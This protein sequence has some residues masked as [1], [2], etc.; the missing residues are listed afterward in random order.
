M[1][2]GGIIAA[3]GYHWLSQ[4]CNLFAI[5]RQQSGFRTNLVDGEIGAEWG[6]L[7][8]L[9]LKDEEADLTLRITSQGETATI[10]AIRLIYVESVAID[11]FKQ[12]LRHGELIPLL[13]LRGQQME[14]STILGHDDDRSTHRDLSA[15]LAKHHGGRA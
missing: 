14:G 13:L 6:N 9:T 10:I 2:A 1:F 3:A 11:T 4:S 12:I 8:I 7:I 15:D 5:E